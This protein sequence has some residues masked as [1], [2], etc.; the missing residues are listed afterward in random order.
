MAE[1]SQ[2]SSSHK[3]GK[4]KKRGK[5]LSTR[6][7]L[8]PMVDLGFLLITFFMLATTLIKPQ[9]MEITMPSDKDVV[10]EE[11]TVAKASQAVTVILG[12]NNKVFYYFGKTENANI[13]ETDYSATG[14][15]KM[16][17]QKNFS[18]VSQVNDLNFEKQKSKM[19]EED[20]KTQLSKIKAGK[21]APVVRIM[22][23]DKSD[24][25]NLVDA[26]D[27]MNI[28]YISRYAIVDIDKADLALIAGKEI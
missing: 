28:C 16:L 3:K 13:V 1:I 23:T 7:D 18:I 19:N 21:D 26:L 9:T 27:E 24:Y 22:A 6:I 4:G 12:S 14:L 17:L 8:T 11:Q 20:Y 25:K 5:K 15:R 2:D 10:E